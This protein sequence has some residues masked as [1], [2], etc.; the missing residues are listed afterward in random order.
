MG[1]LARLFGTRFAKKGGR[2]DLC[3]AVVPPN[4]GRLFDT[5]EVI[6][7]EG[8]WSSLFSLQRELIYEPAPDGGML[9]PPCHQVRQG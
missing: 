6:T 2:C 5:E 8:Y 9:P 4:G 3:D 1:W 7:T